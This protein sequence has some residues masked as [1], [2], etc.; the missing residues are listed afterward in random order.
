MHSIIKILPYVHQSQLSGDVFFFMGGGFVWVVM[1]KNCHFFG[2]G[3]LVEV[4]KSKHHRTSNILV[5]IFRVSKQKKVHD[6]PF[7]G[8]L[9][10]LGL[11]D[12]QI[13]FDDTVNFT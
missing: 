12:C 11:F 13:T 3:G 2:L 6:A 4:I 1:I 9:R 7:N 8:G 5:S 10:L